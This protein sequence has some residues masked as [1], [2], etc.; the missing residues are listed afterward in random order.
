VVEGKILGNQIKQTMPNAKV[1]YLVQDDDFGTDGMRGLDMY[2]D[3]SKVVAREKYTPGN[4]NIGP[5]LA[6]LKARGAEAVV[7]FCIPAY[8]ALTILGKLKIG[9]PAKLVLSNVG[10]DPTTLAALLES[11]AKK[12]GATVQGNALL[13]GITSDAYLPPTSDTGNSWIQLFQKVHDKYVPQLPFDGN[14]EYGMSVAF[15]F[16]QALQKAGKDVTRQGIV[17]TVNKGGF[18]VPGLVPYRF[19][20]TSHAGYGGA[21]LATTT[22]GVT[23]LLGTPLVTDSSNGPITPYT[24]AQPAA[25]ANGIPPA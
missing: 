6:N 17:D 2:V 4:T 7:C 24:T 8:V 22:N 5:Q 9:Y 18:T 13:N 23:T 19:S 14:V 20:A 1:G 3:Q 10:A 12:G 25:P 21:Q 15:L 16:A 11:I